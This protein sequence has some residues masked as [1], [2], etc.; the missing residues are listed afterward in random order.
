MIARALLERT[1]NATPLLRPTMPLAPT[2]PLARHI[3]KHWQAR[4]LWGWGMGC[5]WIDLGAGVG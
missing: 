1:T 4:G 5:D 3:L 2:L